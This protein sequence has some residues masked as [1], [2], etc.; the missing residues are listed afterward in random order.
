MRYCDTMEPYWRQEEW[1]FARRGNE[2]LKVKGDEKIG[3]VWVGN[4]WL[5]S[6]WGRQWCLHWSQVVGDGYV[7][8]HF[9]EMERVE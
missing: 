9:L 3:K 1:R 6:L 8:Q 2:L 7:W 4:L 5:W